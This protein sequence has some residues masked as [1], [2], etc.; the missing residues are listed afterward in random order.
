M[1]QTPDS[2]P[3]ALLTVAAFLARADARLVGDLCSQDGTRV[4]AAALPNDPVLAAALL[5]AQG[6]VEASALRG[7]RYAPA[8]LAVLTGAGQAKL[9]RV[10]RDL[11][12]LKLY[13]QRGEDVPERFARVEREL[14]MLG[15]GEKIFG[16][17]ESAAA[18]IM[19]HAVLTPD[20][21]AAAN[22]L[23]TRAARLFGPPPLPP[24]F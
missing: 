15:D 19:A 7:Q 4:S 10:L 2:S 24:P 21:I 13:Q 16:L 11:T 9:F 8:D 1:A 5:D 12:V 14:E 3:A 20:Q 6:E 18:G 17:A 23:T 22:L